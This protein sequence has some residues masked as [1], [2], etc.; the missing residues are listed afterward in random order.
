MHDSKLLA[1]FLYLSVGIIL[2]SGLKA[3]DQDSYEEE[4][5]NISERSFDDDVEEETNNYDLTDDVR[6]K[7][8]MKRNS[9]SLS[10]G[11]AEDQSGEDCDIP[12][13]SS[14]T[15]HTTTTTKKASFFSNLFGG[16]KKN[17]DEKK[18]EGN[19]KKNNDKKTTT[20]KKSKSKTTT[21]DP[22]E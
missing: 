2:L 8:N 9:D 4:F 15:G 13:E 17:K 5:N 21:P 6:E 3:Q 11:M 18:H 19:K 10:E 20:T 7:N 16:N 12:G 1:L 22:N 14:G